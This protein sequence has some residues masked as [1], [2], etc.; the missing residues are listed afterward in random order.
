M[1]PQRR[2][3]ADVTLAL[4]S[5]FADD[6]SL[7]FLEKNTKKSAD[8]ICICARANCFEKNHPTRQLVT[9]FSATNASKAPF[10]WVNSARD[11]FQPGMTFISVS[12]HLPLSVYMIWSKNEFVPG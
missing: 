7:R 6:K 11:E 12:G 4:F 1:D 9:V 8:W 2:N 3:K 5:V 10:T